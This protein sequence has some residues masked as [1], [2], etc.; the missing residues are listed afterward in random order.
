MS[1]S[2]YE[3]MI[4]LAEDTFAVKNDPEQLDV[5]E[6][7]IEHL[8]KIHLATVSEYDDGN[9]P[10]AW[11]IMIPTTQELMNQFLKKKI[12]EKELVELTPLHKKYEA[13]YLCSAM[14]LE[15][16]RRKGVAK[17][18]SMD[19]LEKIQKEHPIKS[20]FVWAFTKEGDLGSEALAK[21]VSLPLYKRQE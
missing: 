21:A 19:A 6:E 7:V 13:V 17:K 12:S 9:G 5:N 1:K 15:E 14:V 10:A 18:L 8:Q 2:N 3:R 4:Q 20:L 11:I 16:H